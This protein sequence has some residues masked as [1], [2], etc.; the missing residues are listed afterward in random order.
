M[1]QANTINTLEVFKSLKKHRG[2]HFAKVV[3]DNH[4]LSC[5]ITSNNVI[6]KYF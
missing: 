2:E 4:I 6:K 3:R 5:S 1:K